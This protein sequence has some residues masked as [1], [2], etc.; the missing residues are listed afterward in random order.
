[1]RGLLILR[2]ISFRDGGNYNFEFGSE[3]SVEPQKKAWISHIRL[4]E[5]LQTKFNVNMEVLIDTIECDHSDLIKQIFFD[6]DYKINLNQKLDYN[7]T[8]SFKRLINDN[9][10]YMKNFDY[11]IFS[12]NDVFIKE[13]LIDLV[14]PFEQKIKFTFVAE[15]SW[16]KFNNNIPRVDDIFF[17]VPKH[18]FHVLSFV[19][20]GENNRKFKNSL[21]DLLWL[22]M[23]KDPQINYDF[24]INTYHCSE[25]GYDYNPLYKMVSRPEAKIHRSG[26]DLIYPDDF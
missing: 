17:F 19:N 14:N 5:K 4:L 22:M 10:S 21:H 9:L 23:L 11:L 2:G 7:Q 6:F 18:F 15:Y 3:K 20:I 16:R 24:Y 26:A 25:T 8:V 13:Q 12:R 1:M